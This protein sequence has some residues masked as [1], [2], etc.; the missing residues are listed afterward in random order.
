MENSRRSIATNEDSVSM[1]LS[2]DADDTLASKWQSVMTTSQCQ[3]SHYMEVQQSLLLDQT[4]E[5]PKKTVLL[6]LIQN[7]L[8]REQISPLRPFDQSLLNKHNALSSTP[9]KNKTLSDMNNKENTQ[10]DVENT[11]LS[12]TIDGTASTVKINTMLAETNG[13][14][15]EI[16]L[17]ESSNKTNIYPLSADVLLENITEV[18]NEDPSMI[19]PSSVEEVLEVKQEPTAVAADMINEVSELIDKALKLTGSAL[20]PKDLQHQKLPTINLPRP[21]RSYLP[22]A[23]GQMFKQRM[24]IVVKT[25]L[26]SPARKLAATN[27]NVRRSYLP[28]ARPSMLRKST[29]LRSTESSCSS[30]SVVSVRSS[31]TQATYKQPFSRPS[32]ALKTKPA[33]PAVKFNCQLCSASFPVKAQLDL[34]VRKHLEHKKPGVCKYCDKK[35]QLERALHIHLMQNCEKIP[36]SEKRKLEYTELNHVKKAQLPKMTNAETSHLSRMIPAHSPVFTFKPRGNTIPVPSLGSVHMAP[37]ASKVTKKVPHSGVYCTPT[38]LVPCHSCKLSFKSV[39]DYTNHCLAVH[40]S[41][42]SR[43]KEAA[44]APSAQ[45]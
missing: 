14:I 9:T 32:V 26:N 16:S 38:K 27:A 30:S 39:L 19:V 34:H 12:S 15:N 29:M 6:P 11:T 13:T 24:S 23:S 33:A 25:T 45:D 44:N 7:E 31:S 36:P 4:L 40:S 1:Y 21:R 2:F 20:K 17:Q 10:P 8:T 41:S 3:T 28:T 37:P 42:Q 35:F 18:S 43:K 5:E 22:T